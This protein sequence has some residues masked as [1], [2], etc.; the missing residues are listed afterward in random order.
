MQIPSIPIQA[1]MNSALL[2]ECHSDRPYI[3]DLFLFSPAARV[4][5]GRY[6]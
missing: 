1:C 2:I 6:E 5:D 4:G 3:N